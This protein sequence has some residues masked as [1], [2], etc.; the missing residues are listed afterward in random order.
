V[1][2]PTCA[3]LR[4][5]TTCTHRTPALSLAAL[6]LACLAALALAARADAFIYWADAGT[7]SIAR[8]SLD[9]TGV[10]QSFIAGVDRPTA[11]AV[12]RHYIYWADQTTESIGRA[13]LDGTGVDRD[14]I[15]GTSVYPSAPYGNWPVTGL[16]VGE[17]LFWSVDGPSP[18][19]GDPAYV[20]RADLDGGDVDLLWGQVGWS[21]HIHGVSVFNGRVFITT[22]TTGWELGY[23]TA[24]DTIK[25]LTGAV[26]RWTGGVTHGDSYVFWLCDE[27]LWRVY[28]LGFTPGQV[29]TPAQVPGGDG[30][31]AEQDA[32]VYWA[33]DTGSRIG[34]VKKDGSESTPDFLAAPVA[35]LGVAADGGKPATVV[36]LS[37]GRARRGERVTVTGRHFGKRRGAGSVRFG[38]AAAGRYLR[39]TDRRIVV[40]VPA[41]ARPGRVKLAVRT[42]YGQSSP[43]QFT[44]ER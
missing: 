33:D 28:P 42:R 5:A 15:Q 7:H 40:V 9:G 14:F 4:A 34:R 17:H 32:Y 3:R 1:T 6:A 37:A 24:F 25:N 16:A 44:V 2:T 11:V 35:P 29:A 20:G 26:Y 27:G 13:N 12:D 31:L 36:G 21:G 30:A 22:G 41:K 38:R 39:W 23:F 19:V 18:D 8:A 43:L 10:Q